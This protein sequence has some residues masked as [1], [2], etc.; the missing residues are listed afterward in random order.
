MGGNDLGET[1]NNGA[2]FGRG[3]MS[4]EVLLD[5]G[6]IERR[7]LLESPDTRSGDHGISCPTIGGV[8]A[9]AHKTFSLQFVD[10]P[11]DA[12]AREYDPLPKLLHAESVIDGVQLQ[13]HVIPRERNR[14]CCP[15]VRLD[16]AE[17]TAV[18]YEEGSPGGNGVKA[19][20]H[21]TRLAVCVRPH[22]VIVCA[23]AHI[24]RRR[25]MTTPTR[26]INNVELPAAGTWTIDPGH[27]QVGFVGRH[28]G[29]TKVRGRF[30]EVSGDIVI[31]DNIENSTVTVDI[32]VTS[33]SSGDQTRD[34][35]L[36]SE[37]LFDVATHPTATFR[38]TALSTTTLT[39]DLTIKGITKSVTLDVDYLGYAKDPWDNDRAIFSAAGTINREDWGL[40]WNMVL[41]AGGLLVSK[42][43]RL[44]IEVE[45]ILQKR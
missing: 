36:R 27:A 29:L 30:T 15:Q 13:Q 38:S 25:S 17:G 34:D 44:E 14:S 24:S 40:T 23:H 19:G 11:T 16:R 43:I 32:D 35:H 26:M 10:E 22:I 42:E 3:E 28:F 12:G 2:L 31:A 9:P 37:D 21:D 5:L 8:R 20:R 6:E 4:C 39:G 7:R 1:R 33:V 45:L 41:E 18:G